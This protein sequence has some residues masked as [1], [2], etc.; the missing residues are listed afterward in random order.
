[1]ILIIYFDEWYFKEQIKK[2]LAKRMTNHGIK[3][4]CVYYF[5]LETFLLTN[6]EKVDLIF[7]SGSAKRILRDGDMFP[8][9]DVLMRKKIRI[10]GTCFGFH[11]LAH[12]SRGKIEEGRLVN[13]IKQIDFGNNFAKDSAFFN[14]H[15]R[16]VNLPKKWTVV[17]RS[18]DTVNIATTDKWIGYLF[19]PENTDR[20]FDQYL[21]PIFK[22]AVS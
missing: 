2:N 8:L 16:I 21:L 10:V 17:S 3:F 1:M 13:G 22:D 5:D 6:K 9:I 7:L 12:K 18:A 19:H 14:Y 20:G 15:D 4:A 11:L